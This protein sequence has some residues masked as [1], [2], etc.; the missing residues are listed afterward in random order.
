MIKFDGMGKVLF[1]ERSHLLVMRV[2]HEAG[3]TLS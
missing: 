3:A 1:S 2:V